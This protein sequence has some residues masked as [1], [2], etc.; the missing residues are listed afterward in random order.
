VFIYVC[1]MILIFLDLEKENRNCL[2]SNLGFNEEII[3]LIPDHTSI[4]LLLLKFA[5]DKS[6]KILKA[7]HNFFKMRDSYKKIETFT[8][9]DNFYQPKKEGGL[10]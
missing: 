5:V 4:M 6:C 10:F 1:K 8:K 7:V 3:W 9:P 2:A